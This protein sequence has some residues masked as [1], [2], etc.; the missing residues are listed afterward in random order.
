MMGEKNESHM[1]CAISDTDSFTPA[2][3]QTD[4]EHG[5]LENIFP[6]LRLQD[7]GPIEFRFKSTLECKITKS[8]GSNIL[9]TD[10]VTI[11][12]DPIAPLFCHVNVPL[13]G[14]IISSSTNT[15]AYRAYSETLLNYGYEAKNT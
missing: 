5:I 6:I 9:E 2:F 11:I 7:D 14:K 15:Y 12:N 8:D 1:E 10:K 4:I 13:D 3:V